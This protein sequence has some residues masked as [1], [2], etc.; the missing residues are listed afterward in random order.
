M[1]GRLCRELFGPKSVR[2]MGDKVSESKA[3]IEILRAITGDEGADLDVITAQE[4]AQGIVGRILDATTVEAVDE[5]A[6][7]FTAESTRDLA[8]RVITVLQVRF[9]PSGFDR[10]PGAPAIYAVM[11]CADEDG[12]AMNVRT[13]GQTTM[14]QLFKY[15]QLGALPRVVKIVQAERPTA[16]GFYPIWLEPVEA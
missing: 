5:A 12:E 13:S 2:E 15:R 1:R 14:A 11:R 16:S 9:L 10:D 6:G 4:M 7:T 8:G 3:D